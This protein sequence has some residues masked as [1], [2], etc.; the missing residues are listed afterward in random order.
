M[1]IQLKKIAAI[2]A[3]LGVL[4]G[5]DR[6]NA[7]LSAF[8][9]NVSFD[10]DA[11]LGSG[12]GV[13][14]RWGKSSSIIGGETS[15]T[16]AFPDRK[17]LVAGEI[18]EESA[19]ALIYEARILLNIPLGMAVSPFVGA[20]FGAVTV[21]SSDVP[22]GADTA[23][24]TLAQTQT[25]SAFSWGGGLRYSLS[26]RLDLRADFRQYVVFSVTGVALRAAANEAGV[27]LE[28]KDNTVQHNK[29]SLGVSVK[30]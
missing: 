2:M 17:L 11:N 12:Q 5:S 9:A 13:G 23:I 15:V 28:E 10:K 27:P 3:L 30:F 14:L 21:T 7:D 22:K 8:V 29:I 16:L 1:R 18:A 20:G 25:N 24:K 4:V 6:A 19:T 26:E